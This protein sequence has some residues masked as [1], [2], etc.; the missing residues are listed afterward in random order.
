MYSITGLEKPLRFLEVKAPRISRQ[1]ALESSKVVI[2]RHR[3]LLLPSFK[4][5]CLYSFMFQTESN[6]GHIAAG[7]MTPLEIEFRTFF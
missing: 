4:R 7:R 2:P 6:T 5:Y 3:P 1:L